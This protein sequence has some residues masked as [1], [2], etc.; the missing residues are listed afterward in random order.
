MKDNDDSADYCL[1]CA[2]KYTCFN[3]IGAGIICKDAEGRINRHFELINNKLKEKSNMKTT[4]LMIGDYVQFFEGRKLRYEK[5]TAI[6]DEGND[7]RYVQTAESDVF[8]CEETYMPIPLTADILEKNF[9]FKPDCDEKIYKNKS[10]CS[11]LVMKEKNGFSIGRMND[12]YDTPQFDGWFSIEY[13]HEL[14][15]ALRMC[16]I[17]KEIVL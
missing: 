2:I 14:Q 11:F 16:K 12:S 3:V 7:Q 9:D 10:Y 4:E 17:D 15:H 1:K 8:H 13:V 5:V 6:R